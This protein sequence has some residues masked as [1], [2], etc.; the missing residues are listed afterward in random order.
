MSRLAASI[1]LVFAL[2]LG[3][4]RG[5]VAAQA[6]PDGQLTVAFD[7][8]KRHAR[9]ECVDTELKAVLFVGGDPH[10]SPFGEHSIRETQRR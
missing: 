4:G 10:G 3:L 2:A 7:V 6:Q 9:E 5:E 1:G 8:S